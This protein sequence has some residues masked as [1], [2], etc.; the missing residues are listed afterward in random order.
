MYLLECEFK[1]NSLVKIR[2]GY[3]GTG[4]YMHVDEYT[5]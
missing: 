5:I 4:A 1:K 3:W 2:W